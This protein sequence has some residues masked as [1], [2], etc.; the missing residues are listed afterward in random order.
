[1]KLPAHFYFK[2]EPFLLADK[3]SFLFTTL[4]L[5]LNNQ[6]VVTDNINGYV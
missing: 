3:E 2:D 6:D 4:F 1:M 5:S